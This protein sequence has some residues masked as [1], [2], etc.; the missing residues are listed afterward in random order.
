MDA[1]ESLF[2]NLLRDHQIMLKE[3]QLK[4][5]N[6]YFEE[7]ISWNNKM[8]LTGITEREQVY[9]KHFFDSLTISFYVPF[10]QVEFFADIGSGAGFPSIPL[11]ILFPHLKVM[12]VD[13]LSKRIHFLNHLLDV[14]KL[15]DVNCIHGRAEDI[16]RIPL[17]RNKF[18]LVTARAVAKLN[19]LNELCLP[20][21]KVGGK[22]VAMKGT[23]P[24]SEIN[25][26]SFS[27][28]ELRSEISQ[29]ESFQLPIDHSYRHLVIIKK[30]G[31][32]S[33][34]YPRKAGIPMKEP[35]ILNL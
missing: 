1:I 35:L 12:I 5:F 3:V 24:E 18:D 32:T 34:K 28:H 10:L 25:E 27:L 33:S 30:L 22:F 7:L 4:Q 14:L 9:I 16:A 26:S 11:K 20:Y 31:T 8:N 2:F 21:V 13:S 6:M 17:Y 29:I 19:V 15:S 23:N